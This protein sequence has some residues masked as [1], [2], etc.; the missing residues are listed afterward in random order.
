[1]ARV[2]V[3][4]AMRDHRRLSAL[5]ACAATMLLGSAASAS[6]SVLGVN[7]HDDADDGVCDVI[8]CSLREAI[9]SANR[10]ADNE[11]IRFIDSEPITP[12]RPLPAFTD[13]VFITARSFGRCD[14][15]SAPLTLV[16]NS[17]DFDGLVFAPGSGGSMICQV[18]VRGFKDGIELQ[19]DDNAIRFSRIGTL[20]D[21]SAAE[22]NSNFGI[23]VEGDGNV[24][25][26]RSVFDG[27]VISGNA[28]SG[29]LVAEATA[30]VIE[31]NVIGTDTT[32]RD[33][34]PNGVGVTVAEGAS[35]TVIGGTDRGARNMISGNIVSGVDS[36]DGRVVGNHIGL[37][38]T[39]KPARP[40][41]RS[42]VRASAPIQIG[43]ATEAERNVIAGHET[44]DVELRAAA[45]VQGNWIGLNADGTELDRDPASKREAGVLLLPGAGRATIGGAQTGAGN[46]IA[47]QDAGIESRGVVSGFSVKGNAIGLAADG[48]RPIET[49]TGIRIG[50]ETTDALVGGDEN[51]AGNTVTGADAASIAVGGDRTRIEGNTVGLNANG[52]GGQQGAPNGITVE[53]TA[54]ATQIGGDTQGAG[55]TIS[56]S[57]AGISLEE[58]SRGT[59]VEG[60]LIGTD[61]ERHGG[62]A[63][64]G[65]DRHRRG[66]RGPD[67]RLAHGPAQRDLR[68]RRSRGGNRRRDGRRGD[69]GQLHR[70]RRR[71]LDPARQRRWAR[72]WRSSTVSSRSRRATASSSAAPPRGRGTGS[73]TTTAPAWRWAR[74][75][76]A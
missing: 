28:L 36:A 39:G 5:L 38:V 40:N 15:D 29:V 52:D 58:D 31:G 9:N 1:M 19:S 22:G 10:T 46:V 32:G 61:E 30:T 49:G 66:G 51:G 34:I 14:F 53:A 42:G 20:R 67:R 44:A 16:G 7:A 60:N 13:T 6:A 27:N 33:A 72:T 45:T 65:R 63:Q 17:A 71:R 56:D 64:R 21:G 76:R 73:P 54:E 18:N 24:I 74:R 23:V 41:G 68:Q 62:T 57:D 48:R 50:A 11:E 43:G 75:P 2:S 25:G 26:G 4:G 8:H 37:D 70:G 35:D 12:T 47:G 55:N 3:S 69:R 59:V